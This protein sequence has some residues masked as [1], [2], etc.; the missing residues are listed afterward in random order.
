[1]F[2]DK[3]QAF[4]KAFFSASNISTPA[5]QSDNENVAWAH[6]EEVLHHSLRELRITSDQLCPICRSILS[7]PTE[8]EL[9]DLLPD[10]DEELDIVLEIDAKNIAFPTLFVTFNATGGKVARL[11]RRM[12]AV[13]D[14]FLKDGG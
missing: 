1:M 10:D 2:C 4:F 8:W 6:H 7:S 13:C 5:Y 3:C 9:R 14:G 11:P 12:L